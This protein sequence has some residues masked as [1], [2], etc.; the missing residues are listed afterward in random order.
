[1]KNSIAVLALVLAACVNK[2]APNNPTDT[3]CQ[4]TIDNLTSQKDSMQVLYNDALG[5]L[6]SIYGANINLTNLL[7]AR[8][9]QIVQLKRRIRFL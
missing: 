3:N 4:Q 7:K 9:S 6:D 5:R 1:M 8:D 2:N